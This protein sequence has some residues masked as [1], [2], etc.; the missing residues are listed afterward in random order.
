MPPLIF[1]DLRTADPAV[2]RDF[3]TGLPGWTVAEIASVPM[4]VDPEQPAQPWGGFTEL[5][6]GDQRRP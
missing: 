6:E 4:F 5:A 3:Y 2:S 1:M